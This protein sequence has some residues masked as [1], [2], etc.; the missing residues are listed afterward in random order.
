MSNGVREG[1]RLFAGKKS[2][3]EAYLYEGEIRVAGTHGWL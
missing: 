2:F 1:E 3:G